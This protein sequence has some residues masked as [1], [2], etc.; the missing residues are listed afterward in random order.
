MN[1]RFHDP[2]W[3]RNYAETINERRPERLEMFDH[4]AR[5]IAPLPESPAVVELAP[6]PGMLAEILLDARPTSESITP[7]PSSKSHEKNWPPTTAKSRFIRP[8]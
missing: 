1:H 6:G 3:V 7:C 2:D 4:I 8:I 5:L